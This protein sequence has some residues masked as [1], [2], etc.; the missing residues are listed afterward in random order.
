MWNF[1]GSLVTG[2]ASL[3]GGM[4]SSDTSAKNTQANIQMQRETNQMSMEEAQRNRDFQQQMSSTAYQR[5]SSDMQQAGLNPAMMFGSGG[6]ASS[7]GGNVASFGTAKSERTSP[8]AALGDA[9]S[10]VVSSAV[11]LKTMDKMSDEMANLEVEN[12]RLRE[13][14]KQVATQTATE[15][16]RTKLVSAETKGVEQDTLAKKLD[17]ARQEWEAIKYLDLS[18]IPDAARKFGNIGSWAGGKISDTVS[19]LLSSAKG[20]HGLLPKRSTRERSSWD[21]K[22]RETQ[23]FDEM[24]SNRIR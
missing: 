12:T 10:K 19:P 11:Q 14:V 4:F 17:R 21:S 1:L 20:V 6:A 13:Q 16:Q 22:G 2:G 23:S 15:A 24:W 3:L 8:F 18:G 5:A 9:A 7:P